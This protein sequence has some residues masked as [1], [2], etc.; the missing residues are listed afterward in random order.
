MRVTL[1]FKTLYVE[2]ALF[3]LFQLE[4]E[5]VSKSQVGSKRSNK[6]SL[7]DK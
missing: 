6:W 4:L 5:R 1:I 2:K 7:P 3:P